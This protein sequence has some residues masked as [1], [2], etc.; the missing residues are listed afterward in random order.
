MDPKTPKIE[1]LQIIESLWQLL[2][3]PNAAEILKSARLGFG[4]YII[5]AHLLNCTGASNLSLSADG[6]KCTM[7]NFTGNFIKGLILSFN[8]QNIEHNFVMDVSVVKRITL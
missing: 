8:I 1:L 6:T 3:D 2:N 5:K 4:R 7:D